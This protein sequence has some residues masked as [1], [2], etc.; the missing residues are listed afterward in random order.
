MRGYEFEA[1]I[2]LPLPE[3]EGRAE[4]K[5]TPDFLAS[6]P[7]SGT[8]CHLLPCF[9]RAKGNYVLPFARLHLQMGEG[10]RRTDEGS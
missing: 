7:S 2:L 5:I 10:G 8:T 1:V 4:G 6:T 3:G 9:A